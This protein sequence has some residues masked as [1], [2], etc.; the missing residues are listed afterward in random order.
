MVKWTNNDVRNTK[1][2]TKDCVTRTPIKARVN[3]GV[4]EWLAVAASLEAPVEC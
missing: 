4:P 3:S 2:I 1:Q